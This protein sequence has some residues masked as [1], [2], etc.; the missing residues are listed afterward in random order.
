MALSKM[1]DTLK[2]HIVTRL[3]ENMI[4]QIELT[5]E[6]KAAR[7]ADTYKN[8]AEYASREKI[9]TATD[10]AKG[11][12]ESV[13]SRQAFVNL[14]KDLQEAIDSNEL[15][16]ELG[17]LLTTSFDDFVSHISK[18]YYNSEDAL[19]SGE[20]IPTSS[21]QLRYR[22][23][24]RPRGVVYATAVGEEERFR[25]VLIFK[26]MPQSKF[27]DEFIKFAKAQ[28]SGLTPD[29]LNELKK[30]L[31]GGHLTGVFTAR[32]VR[33]FGL[34]RSGGRD[35]QFRGRAADSSLTT[36]EKELGKIVNLVTDADYLS[37]NIV[38][39]IDL[40]VQTDKR[41]Y[42]DSGEIE[43][44]TEIQF[45]AANKKAGDMLTT[46]GTYLSKLISSMSLDAT[47]EGKSEAAALA[48]ENLVQ[49]LRQV[50][51]YIKIRVDQIRKG[52]ETANL[53]TATKTKLEKNL[54]N[55]LS[56]QE[57]IDTLLNTEGSPNIINHLGDILVNAANGVQTAVSRSK[58]GVKKNITKKSNIVKPTVN[59]R[60]KKPS[61][62]IGYTPLRTTR[63]QF[64][65]LASL[66]A[67]LD[68]VLSEVIEENM[69]N[70][71]RRD[72][73]NLQTGR[74]AQ[75]VKVERLSQS[76]DGMITAFYTY[77]KN[78]YQTFEPGYR[79]GYPLS[80]DPKLLIAKSIREIAA[81]KVANRMRAVRI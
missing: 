6:I 70:G 34:T 28:S 48:F 72:I 49:S 22:G 9:R 55:I 61:K 15:S 19:T 68:S 78:P 71:R 74:F 7:T 24:R 33:A 77:M 67:L 53:S 46:A 10:S 29:N 66:Q 63:G 50:S 47:A 1:S 13:M 52:L 81:E 57:S 65:S 26:N 21:T 3:E 59:V 35:M 20:E 36:L 8:F 80:R 4:R 32:L 60:T 43:L 12:H 31:Q 45:A 54:A 2:N 37:S 5:P 69:G 39:D 79:Q 38:Y 25:D 51:D 27:V 44:T 18:T 42:P 76:R 64:Y 56:N 11:G 73:L 30:S 17:V 23:S 41:L 40:F 16:K 75:S 62:K 14:Q 58:V